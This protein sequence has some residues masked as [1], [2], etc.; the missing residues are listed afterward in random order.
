ME[1]SENFFHSLGYS[2]DIMK[3]MTPILLKKVMSDKKL[4]ERFSSLSTKKVV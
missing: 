3:E 4:S 2:G 1:A